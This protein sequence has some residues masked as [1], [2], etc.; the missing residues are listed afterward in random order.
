LLFKDEQDSVRPEGCTAPFFKAWPP[1]DVN[2]LH[3]EVPSATADAAR[4][5]KGDDQQ[6]KS[7]V[8]LTAQAL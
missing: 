2:I 6:S 5:S 3:L 8:N 1:G 4:T 7:V